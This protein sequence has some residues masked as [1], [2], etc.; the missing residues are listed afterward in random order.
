MTVSASVA[1]RCVVN[2]PAAAV[3][4]ASYDPMSTAQLSAVGTIQVRC[5]RGTGYTISL[6]SSSNFNMTGP[7]GA[8]IP[9][10]ILQPNG[11]TSWTASPVNVPS[12][13]VTSSGWLPY[14][15]TVRPAIGADV[16]EGAYTDTVNITVT[17]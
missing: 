2:G 3:N 8:V 17:Y 9:Y 15:A 13:A 6:S 7:G 5:V 14:D 4:F 10:A 11:S 12:S 1:R 16:P